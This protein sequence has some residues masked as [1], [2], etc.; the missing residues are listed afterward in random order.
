MLLTCSF[1]S[2]SPLNKISDSFP[3]GRVVKVRIIAVEKD[4]T[5]LVASIRQAASNFKPAVTDI[6]GVEIGNIVEGSVTEIHKDNAILTLQ[7]TQTRALLSLKNLANHRSLSLA[8]LRVILKAGDKLDQLV[9][10]TRNTEKGFVIVANKPKAKEALP[11][12]GSLSMESITIGQV[13]GGRV[14]RHTRQGTLVKIT[15][16]IG[17]ILHPTDSS[18]DFDAGVSFPAIDSVLKATVVGIDQAKKQLT[19]STRHSKMYPDKVTSV[20]DR[21]IHDL[22]DLQ[23]GETVRG[24][25]KSV[26]E[27]GLFV[28]VGRNIDAR[29]QIRELFDEVR[30]LC[31]FLTC[32]VNQVLFSMSKIGNHDLR[33][34]NL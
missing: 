22:S 32:L 17:G 29:V 7:P 19:L 33:R 21:E 14:T 23:A 15:A 8:Q 11:S 13:L 2:E 27:H 5:R 6:S 9:V 28:T 24:F 31:V 18:D 16:H 4:Q 25:I 1:I 10:V 12:K 34:T 30:K 26:A 20:V 3:V